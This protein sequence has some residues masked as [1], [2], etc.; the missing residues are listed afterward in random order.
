MAVAV[1]RARNGAVE[2]AYEIVGPP[3]GEPL[4]LIMGLDSPMRWWPDGFCFALAD[5][6]FTVAR[7]DNRG[8][9]RSSR[10][11]GR[12]RGAVGRPTH[13]Y[14][15]LDMV[16]DVGAVLDALGWSSAHLVG[17]SLGASVAIGFGLRHPVRVGTIT[18]I[19]GLPRGYRIAEAARYVD[20]RGLLRMGRVTARRA[21]TREQ[22]VRQQV[23]LARMQAAP[24]QPFDELW[25]RDTAELVAADGPSDPANAAR[26]VAAMR[27]GSGMLRHPE[28]LTVPLV[29]IHGAEDPLLRPSAAAALAR[30]VPDGRAVVFSGMGH[31]V[32]RRLWTALADEIS[33]NADRATERS[34]RVGGDTVVHGA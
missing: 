22:D 32:P 25:A 11:P 24:S 23:E 26:Q 9:G 30:A 27:A 2:L 28:Q 1:H 13:G 20:P 18:S 16:G 17:Q 4:L 12:A 7:F 31:E 33:R 21:H 3:G 29:A 6:G 5:R 15:L 14:S 10:I 34:S 19:S 8:I